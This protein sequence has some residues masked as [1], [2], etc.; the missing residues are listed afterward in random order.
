MCFHPVK[1]RDLKLCKSGQDAGHLVAVAKFLF[2]ICNNFGDPCVIL[3]LVECGIKVKLR[4]LFNLNAEVVK[5]LYRS[6][7]SEEVL[8]TRAE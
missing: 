3:M 5:L 8:R 2:H 4:V 1:K 7:T 6:V